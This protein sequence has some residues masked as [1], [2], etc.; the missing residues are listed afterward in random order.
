[1]FDGNVMHMSLI[2]TERNYGAIDADDIH[3]MVT[4]LSTF[5]HLHMPFSKA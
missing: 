5:L 2:F 3:V 4:I 1:M